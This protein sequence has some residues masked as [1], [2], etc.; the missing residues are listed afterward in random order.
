MPAQCLE[1][2]SGPAHSCFVELPE[3]LIQFRT[4]KI[5]Y[6]S[7]TIHLSW[8]FRHTLATEL[9]KAPDRN[10]QM[11]RGLLGHHSIATT[12]EYIDINLDIAGRALER[13]LMQSPIIDLLLN[14]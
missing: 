6:N 7:S 11:V 9:M 10:L 12:M 13:E 14:N 4:T 2:S 8:D 3:Y 5:D 1:L